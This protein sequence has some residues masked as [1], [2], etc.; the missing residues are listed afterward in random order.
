MNKTRML[1]IINNLL[2]EMEEG[3]L[4]DNNGVNKVS[5]VLGDNIKDNI[6]GGD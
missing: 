6:K 1:G 3:K 5:R 2:L 4:L